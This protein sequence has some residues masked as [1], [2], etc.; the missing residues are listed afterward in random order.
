MNF[1]TSLSYYNTY[2]YFNLIK[3]DIN[4]EHI[5]AR[6][7]IKKIFDRDAFIT[8]AD[9]FSCYSKVDKRALI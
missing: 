2:I 5:L 6:K 9:D 3:N 8:I 4:L 1:C 7:V